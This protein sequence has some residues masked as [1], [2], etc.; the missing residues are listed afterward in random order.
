[1]EQK[2]LLVEDS[3]DLSDAVKIRL[4]Q[5][6]YKILMTPSAL[7][8]LE[9]FKKESPD[10]LILDILLEEGNGMDVLKEIRS[11][12]QSKAPVIILTNLD[13]DKEMLNASELGVA[14]YL[15]KSNI[16]LEDLSDK[17]K[18]LLTQPEMAN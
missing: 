6:G 5:D 12:H 15:I 9:I 3:K 17:V 7:E 16:K 13:K 4:S 1:M 18:A 14:Y 2:I 8:A 10:L 11:N